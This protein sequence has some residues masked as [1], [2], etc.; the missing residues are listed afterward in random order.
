M[1]Q[2]KIKRNTV[3]AKFSRGIKTI[4]DYTELEQFIIGKIFEFYLVTQSLQ[5]SEI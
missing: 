5:L 4:L 2:R 3:C 1:D